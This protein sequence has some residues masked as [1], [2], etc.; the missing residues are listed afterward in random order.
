M[1]EL[2]ACPAGAIYR[3]LLNKTHGAL[4][5][6]RAQRF[7]LHNGGAPN[8]ENAFLRRDDEL[9][10]RRCGRRPRLRG[11]ATT[12]RL[13]SSASASSCRGRRKPSARLRASEACCIHV[14]CHA[15]LYIDY[16]WS[17]PGGVIGCH[18]PKANEGQ[19]LCTAPGTG[20]PREREGRAGLSGLSVLSSSSRSHLYTSAACRLQLAQYLRGDARAIGTG[21][22]GNCE[23]SASAIARHRQVPCIPADLA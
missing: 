11:V 15:A 4:N 22:H 19:R 17:M 5:S 2:S 10:S 1:Q 14:V 8:S 12:M 21:T 23:C 6:T 3:L 9:P 20:T 7:R 18:C 16:R 13:I